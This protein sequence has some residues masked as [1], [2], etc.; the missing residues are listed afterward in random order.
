MDSAKVRLVLISS[1]SSRPA[2]LSPVSSAH[3]VSLAAVGSAGPPRSDT[4]IGPH[5][6]FEHDVDVT[7]HDFR[8]R[9]CWRRWLA[10]RLR[11]RHGERTRPPKPRR[12]GLPP[13]RGCRSRARRPGQAGSHGNGVDRRGTVRYEGECRPLKNVK[14]DADP[15]CAKK[16][17]IPPPSEIARARRRETMA[18]VFVQ[19]KG[20][21]ARRVPTRAS[22]RARGPRP[23]RVPLRAPH[24]GSDEG[25]ELTIKNSDGLLHNVHA[26]ARGEQDVQHGHAGLAHR[27]IGGV[28]RRGVHVQDQVRRAPVDGRLRDGDVAPV[29]RRDRERT[30]PSTIEQAA[31]RNLRDRGPGTRSSG[32]RTQSGRGRRG[33]ATVQLDFTFS[34]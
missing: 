10:R 14:M 23:G 32:P 31:R 7:G 27:G 21:V 26:T 15:G 17:S 6:R 19:I 3:G 8:S 12:P 18:N 20:G 25:A 13:T 22:G 16:H 29:L 4:L 1:S 5:R 28:Q 24:A 9:S 11:R 30:A 2:V 34:R 33:S